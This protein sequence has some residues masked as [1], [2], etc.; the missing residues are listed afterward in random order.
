[1]RLSTKIMTS[2]HSVDLNIQTAGHLLYRLIPIRMYGSQVTYLLC[3]LLENLICISWPGSVNVGSLIF[4]VDGIWY[5]EFLPEL[6]HAVHG[7]HLFLMS[8]FISGHQNM[9]LSASIFVETGCPKCNASATGRFSSSR[10]TILSPA[11]N[12]PNH[13]VISLKTEKNSS[14]VLSFWLLRTHIFSCKVTDQPK[15]CVTEIFNQ[16]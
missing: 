4:Y 8:F 13:S 11:V 10:N 14:G 7:L 1:M 16:S 12:K 9:V 3:N 15:F 2:F 5:F 6:M